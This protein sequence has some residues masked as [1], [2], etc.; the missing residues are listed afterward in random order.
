M[1]LLDRIIG[2]SSPRVVAAYETRIDALEEEKLVPSEKLLSAGKPQRPF[3]EIFQLAYGFSQA[4]GKYERMVVW[5]CK[6]QC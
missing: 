6:R 2:A 5:R 3:E 4:L 1:G